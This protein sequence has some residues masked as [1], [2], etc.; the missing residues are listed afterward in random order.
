MPRKVK[1][2]YIP[3]TT[4]I[5]SILVVE[6]FFFQICSKVRYPNLREF[7]CTMQRA[8]NKIIKKGAPDYLL[9]MKCERLGKKYNNQEGIEYSIED[10][11]Y[12]DKQ[13]R[14]EQIKSIYSTNSGNTHFTYLIY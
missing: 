6:N 4:S 2:N 8:K 1:Y 9:K 7:A 12:L 11:E 10:V 14:R 3:T 13:K 5:L